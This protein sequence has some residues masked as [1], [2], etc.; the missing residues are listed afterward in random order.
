MILVLALLLF[1]LC[2]SLIWFEDVRFFEIKLEVLPFLLALIFIL[3]WQQ[4]IA[5]QESV[6]GGLIWLIPAALYHYCRPSRLGRGDVWLFAV[7]GAFFGISDALLG[8]GIFA[9]FSVATAYSYARARFKP[10]RRAVYP[11]AMPTAIA[12]LLV[13]EWR[14]FE[15]ANASTAHPIL[16]YSILLLPLAGILIGAIISAPT[17]DEEGREV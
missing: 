15:S 4:G 12:M 10:L 8:V 1:G 7:A 9:L 2:L 5:W 6:M 13:L 17:L 3:G 11:A 16:A 14:S